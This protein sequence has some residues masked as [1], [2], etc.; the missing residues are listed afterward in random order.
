MKV[1]ILTFHMAFNYGAMLQSYALSKKL[2]DLGVDAKIIDYRLPYIDRYHHKVMPNEVLKKN[3]F[4]L[5]VLKIGYR[6]LK[7]YYTDKQWNRF[8]GF[9]TKRLP[10]SKL[11]TKEELQHTNYDVYICGSDQIWN[12]D[13]TGG[14]KG[15]YFCDFVAEKAKKIAY[16]ASSGTSDINGD[17]ETVKKLLENFDAVGVRETALCKT[18]NEKYDL[19]AKTVI[20]P[21]MLLNVSEWKKDLVKG[22]KYKNY[23]LIYA[24]DETETIYQVAREV[25]KKN[26]LKVIA[27]SYR[28]KEL[29]NDIIQITDAGPE[30]F[31]SLFYNADFICT[32]SFHGTAFSVLFNKEFLCFPHSQYHERTDSL[33]Q[34]LN[35]SNRNVKDKIDIQKI[36]KI[37]YN[38]VNDIL[39]KKREES[40]DFLKETIFVNE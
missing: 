20:D 21:V 9:M 1:G 18:I 10:L 4:F 13:I 17:K 33:L 29:G 25:A 36:D 30:E 3:T 35:L 19:P 14:L 40:I 34:M 26:N 24:F 7:G 11:V 28:K 6:F 22:Q 27:L 2:I 38:C 15:A 39:K 16:A 12:G 37:N 31:V 5:A 23:V 8:Y 32:T